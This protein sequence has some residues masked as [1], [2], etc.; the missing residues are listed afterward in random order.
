[1]EKNKF[2]KE[3]KNNRKKNKNLFYFC[4]EKTKKN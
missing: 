2:K 1:M 3:A 4:N